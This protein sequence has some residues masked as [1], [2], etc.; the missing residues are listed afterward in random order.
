MKKIKIKFDGFDGKGPNGLNGEA[1]KTLE[2]LKKHYDVELSDDP[3]YL[4]FMIYS[5]NYHKYDCVRIF[6]TIEGVCPDFNIADYGISFEYMDYGDRFFRLPN[7]F[8]YPD[9]IDKMLHKHEVSGSD[10]KCLDREFC[11][12]VY[13]NAKGDP[14]RTKLFESVNAYKK[15]N[16]GG[17]YMNNLPDGK[18]IDD[19]I[20]F[21]SQHKFSIAS[22]NTS[23]PG[24]HSEKLVEA[25][26]AGTVPIYWG[27]PRVDEFFDEGAF[28]NCMKYDSIDDVVKKIQEIDKDPELYLKLLKTPAVQE[29]YRNHLYENMEKEYECFLT[30]IFDQEYEKAFRRNRGIA[31][32]Q[33]L[34]CIRAEKRIMEKYNRI[35]NTKFISFFIK[36]FRKIV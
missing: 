5:Q 29:K 30:H 9:A 26:A 16:S 24:Y 34:Q 6:L 19:K 3:D 7:F 27:D 17:R 25:F 23:L 1:E 14:F 10:S 32:E 15:V 20:M 36:K 13:S 11:S 12:Y 22:E 8:F 4:F 28:I 21:E 2:I 33:Y 18:P 31:G 35:K